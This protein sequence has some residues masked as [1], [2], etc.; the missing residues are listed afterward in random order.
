MG[1]SST[2]VLAALDRLTIMTKTIPNILDHDPLSLERCHKHARLWVADG[3]H[4]DVD[5]DLKR[6]RRYV[7]YERLQLITIPRNAVYVWHRYFQHAGGGYSG[8]A[9]YRYQI[10]LISDSH[11]L[12]DNVA[13]AYVWSFSKDCY[14]S[15]SGSEDEF[16]LHDGGHPRSDPSEQSEGG[17]AGASRGEKVNGG[18]QDIEKD[19]GDDGSG[20][21]GDSDDDVDNNTTDFKMNTSMTMRMS[22]T[23]KH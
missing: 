9:P 3:S 6:K 1:A 13:F 4:K 2:P 21:S 5:C 14:T 7:K 16:S 20:G 23:T 15:S 10:Y 12:Q 22:L 18:V 11:Y 8:S 17:S 19:N